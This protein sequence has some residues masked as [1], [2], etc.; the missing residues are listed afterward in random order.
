MTIPPII[1]RVQ[2]TASPLSG[3]IY[4]LT[5]N[6]PAGFQPFVNALT[7]GQPSYYAA[8]DFAGNWEV[9]KGTFVSGQL[10]RTNLLSACSGTPTTFASGQL[11]S[12]WLDAPGSLLSQ[13]GA[14]GSIASGQIAN[15]AVVSGSIAS[16]QIASPHVANGGITSGNIGSGQVGSVHLASG[17]I[18]AQFT[19]TSGSITSGYIGNAAVTS[20]NIASGQIASPHVA[21]GGIQSG[22][23]ASGQIGFGHLANGSVQS[24]TIASGQVGPAQLASG[25]ALAGIT[26]GS[27]AS[28]DIGNNS[29]TSGNIA[30]G[31]I[32]LF[33]MASGFNGWSGGGG[34]S[35]TSG[36]ITSGYI[37]NAAVTSGN[38]AS[39]QIAMSHLASGMPQAITSGLIAQSGNANVNTPVYS[40][41]TTQMISGVRAVSFNGTGAVQIAM[42]SV[43]GTMP[44]V[45]VVYDNVAS[46]SAAQIYDRG[47]VTIGSG[48]MTAIGQ[49]VWVGRS[50]QICNMSGTFMSGGFSSGDVGQM[51]GTAQGTLSFLVRVGDPILW[52]G[53]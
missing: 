20:G 17:T 32:S 3:G 6:A 33:H 26:S 13:I 47:S 52:S 7:S 1:D 48:A 8:T 30:S 39:G 11:V 9:G 38:I 22:N 50:G 18:P 46:G 12:I 45:G 49:P 41:N 34:A 5:G 2:E 28:G 44:A 36:S 31:Q 27:I 51:I 16:G 15:G 24:G 21:A 19:L 14:S 37:G 53:G 29:V 42:A 10:T 4:S 43:S 25:A 40:Q 35:L 23:I